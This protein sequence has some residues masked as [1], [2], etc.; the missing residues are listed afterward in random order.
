VG[1]MAPHESE[2]PYSPWSTL[3]TD[4]YNHLIR[5]IDLTSG[6]VSTLA[7]RQGANS[8]FADGDGTQAT[9]SYPQGVAI[10]SNST[11]ALVVSEE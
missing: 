10:S 9:F 8:P 11:F 6:S 2:L 7:G 5:S 1:L 4:N 3:Q